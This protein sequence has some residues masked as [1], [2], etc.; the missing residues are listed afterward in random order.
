VLSSS[1]LVPG[2]SRLHHHN[3]TRYHHDTQLIDGEC[4]SS[5]DPT[6]PELTSSSAF[7][8]DPQADLLFSCLNPPSRKSSYVGKGRGMTTPEQE[9]TLAPGSRRTVRYAEEVSGAV[10]AKRVEVVGRRVRGCRRSNVIQKVG[11]TFPSAILNMLGEGASSGWCWYRYRFAVMGS[12]TSLR[13]L[14]GANSNA[15]L[16]L[17]HRRRC[18]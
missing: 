3:N 13:Q 15:K 14:I 1:L 8:V 18:R 17:R 11:G 16:V 9:L 6:E 2:M 7:E 5:V 4:Y 10:W 12:R